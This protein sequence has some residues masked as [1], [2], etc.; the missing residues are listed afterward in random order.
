MALKEVVESIH[1]GGFEKEINDRLN[2]INEA[3][4]SLVESCVGVVERLEMARE[5]I[6]SSDKFDRDIRMAALEKVIAKHLHQVESLKGIRLVLQ[7]VKKILSP[8][9]GGG[10]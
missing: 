4:S 1:S 3:I 9:S 2:S 8:G 6:R 7:G 5:L 10:H